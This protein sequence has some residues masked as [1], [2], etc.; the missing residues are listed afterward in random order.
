MSVH[1]RIPNSHSK[2]EELNLQMV[3]RVV[4]IY[5]NKYYRVHKR[6]INHKTK[7]RVLLSS[8]V[9]RIFREHVTIYWVLKDV[10][11]FVL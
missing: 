1:E 10:F 6:C 11:L 8:R 7:K 2:Y 9:R 4:N 5:H 3:Y